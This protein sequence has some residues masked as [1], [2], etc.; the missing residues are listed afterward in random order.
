[1]GLDRSLRK[2]SDYIV[3]REYQVTIGTY[4][5]AGKRIC[6]SEYEDASADSPVSPGPEWKL[7]GTAAADGLLFWTWVRP[8]EGA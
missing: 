8:K 2:P 6:S 5:T 7:I 1:M 4:S 3:E